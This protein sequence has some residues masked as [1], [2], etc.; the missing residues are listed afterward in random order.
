MHLN[1]TDEQK[2]IRERFRRIATDVTSG[3]GYL[4]PTGFDQ[5]I[6]NAI[7]E[8]GLWRTVVPLEYGGTGTDWWAFTAALEGLALGMRSPAILL[9]VIAQAGMVRAIER[10]GSEGQRQATFSRILTG[11]LSA[12][13]IADPDTGT[14]VRATSTT[15]IDAGGGRYFLNGSKFNIAHA[16]FA[17]FVLVVCK[18][19]DADRSG[20]TLVLVDRETPGIIYGDAD[21]KLGLAD[22]PTGPITFDNVPISKNSILGEPGRGL[23]SLVDIVSLGR[24]YYGLVAALMVEPFLID[25]LRFSSSRKTFE[26]P[27]LEHQYI[28]RRLTNIRMGIDKARWTSYAA[29]DHLLKMEDD[30]LMLCSIAKLAGAEIVVEASID[31]L[32]LHGSRGYQEGKV[33]NFVRDAL[34]FCSVG[35]TEEM[36]RKNIFNQMLRSS[37]DASRH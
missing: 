6:W 2:G 13:A 30:A 3:S 21:K 9:S 28:Q 29:L 20:T 10:Y 23:A 31:L 32:K 19:H 17:G 12:T 25:A 16:P 18:M 35:G 11:E 22:L 36:H 34:A 33:A 4:P 5:S 1:W 15:L 14:D 8:A 7:L 37:A 24:L 27:L 26:V